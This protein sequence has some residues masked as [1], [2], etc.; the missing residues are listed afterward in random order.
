[1]DSKFDGNGYNRI[2]DGFFKA[3]APVEIDAEQ[4]SY[5]LGHVGYQAIIQIDGDE[6][7][8]RILYLSTTGTAAMKLINLYNE[9]R[10]K[11]ENVGYIEGIPESNAMG[12]VYV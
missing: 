7:K 4:W 6:G 5:D 11:G 2:E 8:A 10:K 12:E 3:I 9:L 1:M